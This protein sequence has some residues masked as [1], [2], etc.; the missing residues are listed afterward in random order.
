MMLGGQDQ[1]FHARFLRHRRDLVGIKIR[2][3]EHR[4]GFVAIA[5][6]PVGESVYSKVQETVE[7]HFVPAKLTFRRNRT[8]RLRRCN[9]MCGGRI[10]H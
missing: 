10:N 1:S 9:G 8:E 4:L 2:R 3:I 7:L 5:P 6:F